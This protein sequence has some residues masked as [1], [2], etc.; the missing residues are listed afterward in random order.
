MARTTLAA[1]GAAFSLFAGTAAAVPAQASTPEQEA[2][3]EKTGADNKIDEAKI[4]EIKAMIRQKLQLPEQ[5]N[6][7]LDKARLFQKG[8]QNLTS[9]DGSEY[10]RMGAYRQRCGKFINYRSRREINFSNR[11]AFIPREGGKVAHTITS[12]ITALTLPETIWVR[13]PASSTHS[14]TTI[15]PTVTHTETRKRRESAEMSASIVPPP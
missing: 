5:K 8:L 7:V 2:R 11:R 14:I 9:V 1:L 6:P 3:S 15:R 12:A 4:K 10:R 13:L